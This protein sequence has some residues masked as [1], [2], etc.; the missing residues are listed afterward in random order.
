MLELKANLC[1]VNQNLLI[2][3]S[4]VS[5]ECRSGLSVQAGSGLSLRPRMKTKGASG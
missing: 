4:I 3:N 1:L 5:K 2:T